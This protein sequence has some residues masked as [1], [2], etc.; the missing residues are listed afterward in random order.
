M[1]VDQVR[2]SVVAAL[3]AGGLGATRLSAVSG[4]PGQF[5]PLSG[6]AWAAGRRSVPDTVESP[7]G[8]ATVTYDDH[9]VPLVAAS[10][11]VAL[12]Y[13]VGYVQ[14]ADRLF[15]MDLLRRLIDGSLAAVVGERALES[16]TV[17]AQLDF[18]GAAEAGWAHLVDAPHAPAVRAY[19]DGVN[20]YVDVGPRPPEF[21]LLGYEPQRWRPVDTLLIEKLITWGLTGTFDVVREAVARRELGTALADELY[22]S[23]FDHDVPILRNGSDGSGA[24]AAGGAA[25]RSRPPAAPPEVGADLAGWLGRF[26]WPPGIG[27]NSWVVS[28]DYTASGKPLLAN[29]PHLQLSVPP[30]WYEQQLRTDSMHVHGVAFPGVPFVVIGTNHAGAWG[31]TNAGTDTIGFYRY[32]VDG[33][34]YRYRG[35]WRDFETSTR[36]IAVADGPD[37]EVTVRK[38]VHGP[39]VERQGERVGVAWVGHTATET[40]LAVYELNHAGGLDDAMAAIRRWDAPAQNFVYADRDGRTLYYLVGRHPIRRVDGVRVPGDR[41]FDGS[42]GEGEWKG[43]EPFGVSSWSGFVPFEAKPHAVDPPYV[44]TANQRIV[45]SSAPYLRGPYASPYRARRIYGLLD[46]RA[47]GGQPMDAAF[48][49]RVQLDVR[50]GRAVDLVPTLVAAAALRPDLADAAATLASWDR[51]MRPDSRGA[52][53]FVRWFHHYVAATFDPVLGP[54]GLDDSF[55]PAAW[56]TAHLGDDSRVFAGRDRAAVMADALATTLDELDAQGWSV[57]GD[58]SNTGAMTH[59]FD[60]SFLN[61]PAIPAPGSG[62]TVRNYDVEGPH[63]SSWRQVVDL[64]DGSA[65]GVVPG[66]NSGV[67]LSSHYHD[68]LRD[69]VEGRYSPL[70]RP[71]EGGPDITVREGSS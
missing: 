62:F 17:N 4:L 2:R 30:V 67:Y 1:D 3:L 12:A 51:E 56:V 59:P 48:V 57:L 33:E 54:A 42:A 50:D 69:W 27:S 70:M 52:L 53:V 31:F 47:R 44:A 43:F 65:V 7:H 11:D 19:A 25:N 9:G 37:H 60:L 23:R 71:L 49:R 15:Q 58:Y 66:G 55:R 26:E 32:D 6:T 18:R 63:G 46:A 13:A 28:G 20:A 61:Y 36:T 10:D 29:D 5:A 38:T 8:A 14:A 40:S 21:G 16:D 41:I 34:R 22:P 64:A 45:D 39:L 68:Q 24:G 35:A